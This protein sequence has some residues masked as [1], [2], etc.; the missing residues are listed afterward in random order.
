MRRFHHLLPCAVLLTAAL[1]LAPPAAS[2]A[3]TAGW[4]LHAV[5]E[6]S[7]FASSDAVRCGCDRYQLL[8]ENTSG[9]PSTGEV[10]VTDRLPAGITATKFDVGAGGPQ[11][12]AGGWNCNE[13][14]VSVVTCHLAA[15]TD[16]LTEEPVEDVP[17][18]HYAP[19]IEI[20]VKAPPEGLTGDLV[21]E[22]TVQGGGFAPATVRQA[23]PIGRQA[24]FEVSEFGVEQGAAPGVL[25]SQ[26]G[27]HPWALTTNLAVPTEISPPNGHSERFVSPVHTLKGA[28]VELPVGFLGDPLATPRCEES[29]LRAHQCPRDSE[30]GVYALIIEGQRGQFIS[31]EDTNGSGCCQAVYNIV[32]EAG[33]PAEFGFTYSH[34]VPIF[35]YANVV[36]TGTGYR[37]RVTAPDLSQTVEPYESTFTFFGEPGA[38]NGSH[39]TTAFMS[40]PS[41]CSAES[42]ELWK[43]TPSGMAADATAK[44][45]AS[46]VE[47][48]PYGVPEPPSIAETTVYPSLTGCAALKFEPKLALAPSPAGGDSAIEEGTTE[49]DEPSAYSVSLKI[50][51]TEQFSELATPDLRDA[52]VTLPAGVSVSPSAATGLVGCQETGPEGINVGSDDIGSKGQDIGDP[53]AT[54]L[55]EGHAGPGGNSSP[56]DDGFYHTAPGHCP[57]ASSIGTAEVCTPLLP[58][59]A[60]GEGVKVEGEQACEETP[61]IAPLK[62]HIYLAEPKCGGEGQPECTEASA[63]N[64]ELF[65]QYIE[66]AGDG[67]IAKVPGTVAANTTT[68]QLTSTFAENPQLAFGELKLH[69]NGGPRAPLANPQTCGSFTTNALLEPWSH[70]RANPV[71]GTA[72]ASSASSFEIDGCAAAMPFAPSFSA[73][74]TSAAAGR[75]SPFVLQFSRQDREQDLSGLSETMPAGL[76]GKIAGVPECPEAQANAGTC[77]AESQIGITTATAGPGPEP[78]V[79]TG[80]R[81]YFTGPYDGAPFGLSIVV[82]TRAGPFNLGNE[83]IRARILINPETSQVTVVTNPLP[84]SKDGVPFR[85]RLVDTEINRPGFTFNPTSCALQAVTATISAAQG[86]TAS[87]SSP[88]QSTGCSNLAPFKPSFTVSTRASTSKANGASLD[89]KIS[90]KQGPDAG[91]AEES[92]ILKVDTQL[93]LQL[94]SRLTTLQ[95]ACTER[96]FAANP[97]GCP[98]ES[99]VGT[100]VAHTPVLP[101]PLEGP[102]Y[103]VSHGGAAFPD[104]VLVLQG[105]GVT[106]DLTG[107][108]DIKNGI[109]YSKFETTP[110]APISSF[111]LRLPEGPFS[112]LGVDT[113]AVAGESLC[114]PVK[115]ITVSK[116]ETKKV[117]GKKRKVTVKVKE[118]VATSL[119]MPTSITAQDGSTFSQQTPITVSGCPTA[120]AAKKATSAKAHKSSRPGRRR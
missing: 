110:D 62:G 90:A 33:Y 83:V 107:L 72:N 69:F 94:P 36:H 29:Q 119:V 81:V 6:P 37:V 16:P 53:E 61:G 30:V 93:P 91:A 18:G 9:V 15:H 58:N 82:P 103:L 71:E 46:R 27:A 111:E 74:T 21:N 1:A 92:N 68:G 25:A 32:P 14:E 38:L 109:T 57:A 41:D 66:V 118:N 31:S 77:A 102:A 63:T 89:V 48:E 4:S 56:Y 116:K 97:A 11:E 52:T 80:G 24:S 101:A 13:G 120:R 87:V 44:G 64:G 40:G 84:Q 54:E 3:G 114:K 12:F 70:D 67:V 5:P 95:K 100:A 59:V 39:S 28:S 99:A 35:L 20:D 85:L 2:A 43:G 49:A 76:V 65:A 86:A 96:Q 34:T 108:T 78:F 51:Q 60:N 112:I 104:L 115:T 79:V 22:V 45:D 7:S 55:G 19:T 26:A 106:V 73:G 117:H 47:A 88:V 42:E 75:Y 98:K 8:V 17:P 50:P 113:Q 105:D 23:A 10:T